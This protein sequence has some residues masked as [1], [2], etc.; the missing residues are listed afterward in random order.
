MSRETLLPRLAAHV[1]AHGLADASLRPLARAAGTSDRMLLYHFG[2]KERLMAD[3][4]AHLAAQFAA[5]LDQAFPAARAASRQD[6]IAQV[7]A[8]TGEGAFQPFMRVWWDIVSGCASGNAA[9]LEAAGLIMDGLLQ[10]IIDHLP[11]SDPDPQ[12][13]ARMVLTYIEGAQ[14]LAAVGRADIPRAG[15]ASLAGAPRPS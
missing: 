12:S 3:L 8:I 11:E 2:S 14:M 7:L 10:W 4:L 15:L 6:C 13:G 5:A 1:M 9:Y